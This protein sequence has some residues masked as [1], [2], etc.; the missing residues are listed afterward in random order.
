MTENFVTS[1][2]VRIRYSIRTSGFGAK[3]R[4]LH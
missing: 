4:L 3:T 1:E 2:A